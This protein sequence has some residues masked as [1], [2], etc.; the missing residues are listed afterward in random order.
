MFIHNYFY[1]NTIFKSYEIDNITI[2]NN[3]KIEK[4]LLIYIIKNPQFIIKIYFFKININYN[5]DFI[6]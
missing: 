3:F 4:H 6:K 2:E 5:F 1:F